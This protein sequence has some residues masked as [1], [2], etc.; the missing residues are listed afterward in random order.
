MIDFIK[1]NQWEIKH[2]SSLRFMGILLSAFHIFAYFDWRSSITGFFSNGKIFCWGFFS[3][4]Q[5]YAFL[6][7]DQSYLVPTAFIVCAVL[8]TIIFLSPQLIGL[9][10][11][12]LLITWGL[13]IFSYVIDYSLYSPGNTLLILLTGFFLFIPQK[14]RTLRILILC[15]YLTLGAIKLNPGWLTG[16]WLSEY[17]HGLSFK[18]LEWIGASAILIEMLLP[19]GLFSRQPNMFFGSFIGLALYQTAVWFYLG[20]FSAPLCLGTLFFFIFVFF[21]REKLERETVYQSFLRPEPSKAWVPAGIVIYLLLQTAPL[22]IG[23]VKA[24][25]FPFRIHSYKLPLNC[26][27][28]TFSRSGS[29]LLHVDSSFHQGSG[30][31]KCHD[32]VKKH[33]AMDLCRQDP[34]GSVSYVESYFGR[35]SF[36]DK[37]YTPIFEFNEKCEVLKKTEAL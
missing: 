1:S 11:F 12:F 6:G 32:R 30:I 7:A 29:H 33:Q 4:C 28:H 20:S 24:Q 18:A 16:I 21:E 34:P 31:F 10:W 25:D 5:N 22:F 3:G 9:S 36:A 19:L 26:Y 27:Q 37:T 15:Y 17:F 35:R 13:E 14:L 23:P 8:A 2:S